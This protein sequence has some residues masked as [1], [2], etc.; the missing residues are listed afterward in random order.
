MFADGCAVERERRLAR[1][2]ELGLVPPDTAMPPIN[3]NVRP[4]AEFG[5]DEQRLFTRLQSA[6][7]AMLD[8]ADQHLARLVGFLD[9]AGVRDDTIIIVMSDNGASQEGGPYGFVNA[10]GPYNGRKESLS[11]KIARIDDIG[12]PDTH[13]N[14]PFGWAMAAN[15]PLK[16]YKQNTHGGGIRDPL[17]ISWPAGLGTEPGLRHQFAHVSDLVPT[18]LDIVGIEAPDTVNGIPQM[19]LEGQSFAASLTDAA[20]P[21][22]GKA[23]YFEMFGHRGLWQDGWKAVAY[24]PPGKPFD[25]DVWEL[26][27][28][29]VDFSETVNLADR[30]PERLQAMIAQWWAEAERNNVLPLDDRFAER[31]AENAERHQ[32]ARTR[33][34]FHAG[35]GHIPTEVAPDIRGRDYDITAHVDISGAVPEGIL[36]AHGDATSGYALY[37]DQFGRLVHVAN[38]GGELSQVAS[39]QPVPPGTTTLGLRSRQVADDGE[40]RGPGIVYTL[41]IDGQEAGSVRSHLSFGPFVSWSGLDIGRDRGSPVGNYEAPYSFTGRLTHVGVDLHPRAPLDGEM[42]GNAEMARQ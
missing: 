20:A 5:P 38:I 9:Q 3:D 22:R 14:F 30:Y 24:H 29:D 25:D 12:G 8:H 33:F 28:L 10:M 1:Q 21:T 23:Q 41:L 35:M 34:D 26:Y 4:W 39:D 40:A 2:K 27:H 17:V 6:Y 32:G 42:I 15:T 19:P 18:L 7:A 13:T 11:E 36:L 37:I 16:R 31:F